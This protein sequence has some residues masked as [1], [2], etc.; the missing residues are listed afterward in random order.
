MWL[1]G[2]GH[3]VFFH[4]QWGAKESPLVY[5]WSQTTA[6]KRKH[7]SDDW[8]RSLEEG[9]S[10]ATPHLWHTDLVFVRYTVSLDLRFGNDNGVANQDPPTVRCVVNHHD[11]ARLLAVHH[12]KRTAEQKNNNKPPSISFLLWKMGLSSRSRNEKLTRPCDP[13]M[14]CWTPPCPGQP[15]RRWGREWGM[16]G[17]GAL[18]CRRGPTA[19]WTEG[20]S[21]DPKLIC[22]GSQASSVIAAPSPSPRKTERLTL[23]TKLHFYCHLVVQIR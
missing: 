1:S 22:W 21:T 13:Q 5:S 23:R 7:K 20:K 19:T 2:F 16:R 3:S 9:H 18:R 14:P 12:T 4:W 8:E 11:D 10:H 6:T 17:N 15:P